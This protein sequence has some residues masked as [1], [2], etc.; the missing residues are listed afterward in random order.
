MYFKFTNKSKKLTNS[1][2]K[3]ESS[4]EHASNYVA[5]SYMSSDI[6]RERYFEDVKLQMDAKLWAE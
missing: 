5:K 6:P 1:I 2:K 3:F 4:W